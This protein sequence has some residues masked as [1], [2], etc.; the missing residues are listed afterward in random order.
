MSCTTQCLRI[1]LIVFNAIV[2]ITGGVMSGFGMYLLV[3]SQEFG[4]TGTASGIPIFIIVLGFLVL[5]VGSFGCC[6]ASKLS[7]GLL[8]TVGFAMIVGIIIIAEI[9]GA[10]L[11]IV[12]KDKAK[13]GV[14]NYFSN[15]I[16]QIQSDQNKELEEVITKLQAAFNC[17][18]ASAPTDWKDPSLSCCK[19]GEQTPCNHDL[20]Q[21][22]IDAIYAWVKQNLLAFAAAVL[23]L[24]VIEVGSIVAASSIIKRGEYI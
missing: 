8:I 21:G 15:A 12:L 13:E 11:L 3:R 24:S 1:C 10:V 14:N 20:Q 6:S 19:P 22:C 23:I 17:C 9:V 7:R 2:F 4:L 18:G 16:R 5:A